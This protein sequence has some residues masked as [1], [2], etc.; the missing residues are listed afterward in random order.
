MLPYIAYM[1]PMGT[2]NLI[3]SGTG[4]FQHGSGDRMVRV[5]SAAGWEGKFRGLVLEAIWPLVFGAEAWQP[6]QAWGRGRHHQGISCF[7]T[8]IWYYIIV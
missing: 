8:L 2:I 6:T 7:I 4:S 5:A 3:I 1:D